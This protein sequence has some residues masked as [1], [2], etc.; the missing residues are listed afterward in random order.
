ML[1]SRP[2]RDLS[3]NTIHPPNSI[4]GGG[5]KRSNDSVK[6]RD[7][8]STKE[9]KIIFDDEKSSRNLKKPNT[10]SDEINKNIKKLDNIEK[11]QLLKYLD[12][13]QSK[14]RKKNNKRNLKELV[15]KK[16][17]KFRKSILIKF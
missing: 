16:F 3:M 2:A 12:E 13:I 7:I 14:Y 9:M 17:E 8:S 6:K 4:K 10:L 5:N 11:K 1:V 15:N